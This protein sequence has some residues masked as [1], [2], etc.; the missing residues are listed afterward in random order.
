MKKFLVSIGLLASLIGTPLLMTSPALAAVDCSKDP[1]AT[2]CPCA[3]NQN[4]PTCKQLI[5]EKSNGTF[6]TRIKNILNVLMFGIGI[7]SV[8]VIIV[9]SIRFTSSRGDS[10]ATAKARMSITYAVVGL[11]VSM[12]AAAIDNFVLGQL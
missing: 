4:S 8:I 1:T 7:V 12:S 2:G 3:T 11:V 6:D 10:N 9:G 5:S